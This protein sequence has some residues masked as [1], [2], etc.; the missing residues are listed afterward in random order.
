MDFVWAQASLEHH[1][2]HLVLHRAKSHMRRGDP[3][4]HHSMANAFIALP[5]KTPRGYDWR[6]CVYCKRFCYDTRRNKGLGCWNQQGM[7]GTCPGPRRSRNHSTPAQ[8]RLEPNPHAESNNDGVYVNPDLLQSSMQEWRGNHAGSST[9]AYIPITS[10]PSSYVNELE[11]PRRS[12][13]VPR[14]SRSR[15]RNRSWPRNFLG[16]QV[17]RYRSRSED[18]YRRERQPETRTITYPGPWDTWL[19][20]RTESRSE[21]EARN[22]RRWGS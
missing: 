4:R 12:R 22:S 3:F 9:A 16:G 17:E 15:S 11:V 5:P 19:E 13:A 20:S 10:Y 2:H 18:L 1:W 6:K 14:G 8:V 7:G 21:V